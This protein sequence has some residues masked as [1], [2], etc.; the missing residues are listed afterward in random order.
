[1]QRRTFL[2][3][4]LGTFASF[5]VGSLPAAAEQP[6][7]GGA[8]ALNPPPEPVSAAISTSERSITCAG[9]DVAD[10]VGGEGGT[11]CADAM[12]DAVGPGALGTAATIADVGDPGAPSGPAASARS[13]RRLR[14]L[15]RRRTGPRYASNSRPWSAALT[16]PQP[17]PSR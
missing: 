13:V 5:A 4:V 2:M 15:L 6:P 17:W 10:A 11:G 14:G 8:P 7:E 3:G 1:M 9:G 16:G 12:A